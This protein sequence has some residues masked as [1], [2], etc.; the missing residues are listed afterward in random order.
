RSAIPNTA[1]TPVRPVAATNSSTAGDSTVTRCSGALTG[2]TDPVNE[3]SGNTTR[4]QPRAAAVSSDSTWRRRFRSIPLL[5]HVIA[6]SARRIGGERVVLVSMIPESAHA[7]F[8]LDPN[9]FVTARDQRARE[10]RKEGEKDEA[11]AVKAL[12]RPTVPVWAL[13]QV[14]RQRPEV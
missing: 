14:A 3:N 8:A 4:S 5:S 10:L 13:N 2:S 1:A 9:D 7:L 12:R 6:T 11:A